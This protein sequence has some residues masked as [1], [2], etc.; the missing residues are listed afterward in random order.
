MG[1]ESRSVIPE[2]GEDRDVGQWLPKAFPF[3]GDKNVL[4]LG[5]GDGLY[6]FVTILKPT[7]VYSSREWILWCVNYVSIKKYVAKK[8]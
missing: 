4:E 8:T 7:E 2:A 3:G 6:N 5:G 1:T